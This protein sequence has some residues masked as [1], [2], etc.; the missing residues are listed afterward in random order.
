MGDG[1][2][3]TAVESKGNADLLFVVSADFEAVR[4]P[5]QVR[6]LHGN[7][8]VVAARINR[9]CMALKKQAMHLHHPIDAFDVGPRAAFVAGV[10][11]QRRRRSGPD[12]T[13]IFGW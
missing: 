9:R 6:L 3:V 5:T 7:A 8:A 11:D 13:S 12:S 2:A 1:P 4:A 10:V